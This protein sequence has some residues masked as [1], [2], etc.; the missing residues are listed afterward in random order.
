VVIN[1][2]S[3]MLKPGHS[4]AW[5]QDWEHAISF[6]RIASMNSTKHHR[7]DQPGIGSFELENFLKRWYITSELL[8]IS[9]MIQS[10]C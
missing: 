7:F 8:S 2:Y 5:E 1:K 9:R 3:K 6:Y 10:L 4:A